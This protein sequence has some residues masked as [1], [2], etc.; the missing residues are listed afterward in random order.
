MHTADNTDGKVLLRA[1]AVTT[2]GKTVT[3]ERIYCV[4]G[5]AIKRARV[6]IAF[7]TVSNFGHFRSR[8]D[9]PVHSAV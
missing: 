8:H 3:V 2:S 1:C 7:A 5:L 9:A 6:R 4:T